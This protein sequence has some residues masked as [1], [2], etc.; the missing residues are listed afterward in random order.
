M[1][2]FVLTGVDGKIGSIAA[3][4]VLKIR[5]PKQKFVFTSYAS[6]KLPREKVETWKN[7]GVNLMS[8]SYDDI[9]LMI[10]VFEG[11]EAISFI[12][13]WLFGVRRRTQHKNVIEAAKKAGVNR[14]CYTSFVGAGLEKD[15]PMLPQ[16]HKY[17]E[18]LIYES[19]L[20]YSIQ[21]DYLYADNIID[22]FSPSWN[23]CGGKWLCNSGGTPGAY[24]GS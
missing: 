16:D 13:T 11:A 6:D 22:L 10:E 21:R 9:G 2:K 5:N 24:V 20:N 15:L 7:E 17:T 14:I 1:S 12:S 19:G 4:Y 18:Q 8:L 3:D 23:Y